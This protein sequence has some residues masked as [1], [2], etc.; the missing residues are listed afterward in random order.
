MALLQAQLSGFGGW[1]RPFGSSAC[2]LAPS[3]LA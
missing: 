3:L 1:W 2:P